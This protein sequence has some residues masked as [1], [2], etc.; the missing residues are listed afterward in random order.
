M[1]G[2]LCESAYT[3]KEQNSTNKEDFEIAIQSNFDKEK[4]NIKVYPVH[5]SRTQNKAGLK[6]LKKIQLESKKKKLEAQII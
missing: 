6:L 1:C 2:E 4:I 5:F 3:V